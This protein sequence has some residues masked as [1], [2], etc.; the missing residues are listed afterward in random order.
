MQISLNPY[1]IKAKLLDASRHPKYH[2]RTAGAMM[3]LVF[4]FATGVLSIVQE[5]IPFPL[6]TLRLGSLI[7][8]H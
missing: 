3:V 1:V 6:M 8:I 4:D 7:I 2:P 5:Q